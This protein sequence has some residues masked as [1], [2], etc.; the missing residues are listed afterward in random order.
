MVGHGPQQAP[1]TLRLPGWRRGRTGPVQI[2]FH[3]SATELLGA[4]TQFGPWAGA[5]AG[6]LA[7]RVLQGSSGLALG[8]SGESGWLGLYGRGRV[9][10]HGHATHGIHK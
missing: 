10:R 4:G 3:L 8:R 1:L 2:G 5:W 6:R 9:Q 7:I